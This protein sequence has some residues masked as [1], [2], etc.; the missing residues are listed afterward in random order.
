MISSVISKVVI[1]NEDLAKIKR[2]RLLMSDNSP[3]NRPKNE[4]KLTANDRMRNTKKRLKDMILCN[5]FEHFF[6]LTIDSNKCSRVDIEDSWSIIKGHFKQ[7]KKANKDFKYII[8][9]E[10]HGD[11]QS[12]HYHG[13]MY[14]Y[15]FPIS[16]T[17]ISFFNSHLGFSNISK[18]KDKQ[19]VSSYILKYITKDMVPIGGCYYSSSRN[20][21]RPVVLDAYLDD[22]YS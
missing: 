20:M 21:R 6:T 14:G 18:I 1:Y 11:N 3:F 13:V 4:K 9:A 12:I 17:S 10:Y 19:R 16:G 22:V 8:V 5:D 15:P 2:Y 7:C